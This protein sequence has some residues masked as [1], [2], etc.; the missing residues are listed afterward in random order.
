MKNKVWLVPC[1]SRKEAWEFPA[2]GAKLFHPQS[3][4]M[5]P[6]LESHILGTDEMQV[7][8]LSRGG[9]GQKEFLLVVVTHLASSHFRWGAC[10]SSRARSWPTRSVC[11]LRTASTFPVAGIWATCSFL[12]PFRLSGSVLSPGEEGIHTTCSTVDV[13]PRAFRGLC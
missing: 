1:Y 3:T 13:L 5:N 4:R 6:G 9:S 8:A 12:P 7:H 2:K 10:I 11:L